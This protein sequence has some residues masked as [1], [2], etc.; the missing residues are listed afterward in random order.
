M[1]K[2]MTIKSH[3]KD[4]KSLYR[5]Y[6]ENISNVPIVYET[7]N[8]V[9]LSDKVEELLKTTPID[10]ILIVNSV[11]FTVE[12]LIEDQEGTLKQSIID[13]T[14]H[15]RIFIVKDHRDELKTLYQWYIKD[16]EIY[17]TNDLIELS[18]EVEEVL[19]TEPIEDIL[20][21]NNVNFTIEALINGDLL[22]TL[23]TINLEDIDKMYAG[24]K[25]DVYN[26]EE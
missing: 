3:R 10:D 17:E 25:N 11:D 9:V 20:I 22:S 14:L 1:Y 6:S 13:D 24:V 23:D 4:N 19:K 26:S 5:W 12:A 8:I 15:F 21:V 7:S 18:E 16:G 2:I